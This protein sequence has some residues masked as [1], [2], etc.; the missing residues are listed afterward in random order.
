M[1]C[2]DFSKENEGALV[3]H[4]DVV[5]NWLKE[6]IAFHYGLE[7]ARVKSGLVSDPDM[8]AARKLLANPDQIR[9]LLSGNGAHSKP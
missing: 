6:E 7:E 8:Q 2:K 4:Q 1:P 9:K 5:K 3:R